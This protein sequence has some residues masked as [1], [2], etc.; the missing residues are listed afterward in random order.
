MTSQGTAP[1]GMLSLLDVKFNYFTR[2][3]SV[4][5]KRLHLEKYQFE[6]YFFVVLWQK[7]QPMPLPEA[8]PNEAS[9][10]STC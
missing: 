1:L 3:E 4:L 10:A 7:A 6:I 9:P 8:T 2:F 5:R